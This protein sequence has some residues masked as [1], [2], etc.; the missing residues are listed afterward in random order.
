MRYNYL[1]LQ[2]FIILNSSPDR[3]NDLLEN[4]QKAVKNNLSVPPFL[5]PLVS[6]KPFQRSS[7]F[8][9]LS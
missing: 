3:L 4:T 1:I 9:S 2:R 5:F 8:S 7:A 6:E